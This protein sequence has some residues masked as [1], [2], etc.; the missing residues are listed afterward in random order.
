MFY[1]T[2]VAFA[3]VN[4]SIEAFILSRSI[5]TLYDLEQSLLEYSIDKRDFEELKL[6]PL[7]CLPI[8]YDKFKFP[9]DEKIPDIS[10]SD[11]LEVSQIT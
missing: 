4:S 6:G 8:V 7:Q 11:V 5:C 3:K 1:L 2:V 9:Q 10:T